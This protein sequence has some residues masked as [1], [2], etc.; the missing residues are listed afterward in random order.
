MI[1]ICLT[2]PISDGVVQVLDLYPNT[3]LRNQ[4]I[5]PQGQTRY[6][7]RVQNDV[8][9]VNAAGNTVLDS[10]GLAAYLAARV[11]PAGL[12]N[13]TATVTINGTLAGDTI[14]LAGV[15]F[16]AAAAQNAAALQFQDVANSGSDGATATSLAAVINDAGNQA[17]ITAALGGV[18]TIAAAA[19]GA[20]VTLT[21]SVIGS[22]P[23]TALATLATSN[24][25]RNV[26]SGAVLALSV[27]IPTRAQYKA[28][29]DAI[30]ARM[31]AGQ[32]LT[33][34]DVNTILAANLGDAELTSV[35]G[36]ASVGTLAELLAILSGRGFLLSGG[37]VLFSSSLWQGSTSVGSFTTPRQI[38][39]NQFINGE[40]VPLKGAGVSSPIEAKPIRS[41]YDSTYLQASLLYGHLSKFQSGI[42]LYPDSD[43]AEHVAL[44]NQVSH[45]HYAEQT[46]ARVLTVYNEDGTLA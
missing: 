3:S 25:T 34:S 35:G 38:Y 10:R 31:D 9:T 39:G 24:A 18:E 22:S 30:I 14:T 46:N 17:L 37:T 43:I 19:V 1:Y 7:N 42:T 32:T 45:T 23:V 13:P 40:I 4:S 44:P 20:V 8:V 36:S 6:V 26:L 27:T 41:I 28:A 5:D 12:E 16:T 15:I 29:A 33:L 2:K 21:L 11:A